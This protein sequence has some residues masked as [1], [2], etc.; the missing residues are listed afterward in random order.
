MSVIFHLDNLDT[1]LDKSC[2]ECGSNIPDNHTSQN[3]TKLYEKIDT[4]LSSA[5]DMMKQSE[6]LSETLSMCEDLLTEV[7]K[8]LHD[9]NYQVIRVLDKVSDICIELGV[10]NKAIHYCKKSLD[11]CLKFYPKYH[12]STAIQLYRIG[13]YCKPLC[14]VN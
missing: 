14:I 1:T 10:W 13:E 2:S 3:I 11:G 8:T 9:F 7:Q 4:T 6:K 12:P 5:C